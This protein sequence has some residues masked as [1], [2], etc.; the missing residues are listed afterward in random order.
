MEL[1]KVVVVNWEN[2]SSI[3]KDKENVVDFFY[4]YGLI[5]KNVFKY[6]CPNKPKTS[7]NFDGK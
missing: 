2:F 5:S 4:L 3:H 1:F 6:L 7:I